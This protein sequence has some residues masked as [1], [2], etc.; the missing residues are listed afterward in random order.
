MVAVGIA[1]VGIARVNARVRVLEIAGDITVL[2]Q[3]HDTLLDRKRR[4]ETERA[5]L[6][7]PARIEQEARRL[8]MSVPPPERI[9]RIHMRE[10]RKDEK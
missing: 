9:Q 2:T 3:Q 7:R 1:A 8:G 10:P 5:F 6:R 4:L